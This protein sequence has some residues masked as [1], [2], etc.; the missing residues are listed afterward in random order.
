[1][2][3]K[4]ILFASAV[5]L[6][7]LTSGMIYRLRAI[8]ELGAPGLVVAKADTLSGLEVVL[9]EQVLDYKSEKQGALPEE[10]GYLPDDT[11]YGRRKYVAPDGFVIITSVVMMGAD[12]TSIHR[13]EFCLTGQGW[14]IDQ[15]ATGVEKVQLDG[16]SAKDLEYNRMLLDKDVDVGDGRTVPVRGMYLY[17][18]VAD[19]Q[20]TVGQM[21]RM[22]MMASEM[23]RTGKLQRWAYVA[24]FA[25]CAP[26][27]E[28]E[29]LGR[30]RKFIAASVP[31]FQISAG[32]GKNAGDSLR[33]PGAST[34]VTSNEAHTPR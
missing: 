17:W 15:H 20:E 34:M 16:P 18:F 29:A 5:A 33:K 8:Q 19:G 3:T 13:P 10:T 31:E 23:A 12:R 25:Y 6:M 9:P 1:M 4:W 7:L 27:Q 14:K 24:Y 26:E 2:K 30:L 11:T 32:A 28:T 21:D 22:L